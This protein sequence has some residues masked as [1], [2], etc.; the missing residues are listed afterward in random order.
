MP[1]IILLFPIL[2]IAC[3]EAELVIYNELKFDEEQELSYNYRLLK[4]YFY[5]PERIKEYEKYKGMEVDLMYQSLEDYFCG[6]NYIGDCYSR[7]TFYLPPEKSEEKIKEIENTKKYYSFG[8]ERTTKDDDLIDT[9][10]VSAVYPISPAAS[11][12]LKKHDKLLSANE[13]PLINEKAAIYLKSDSLFE[14]STVF[15]VLRGKDILTLPAM[16]KKEIQKPTVYLDSLEGIPSIRVTEYKVNTN[17]PNGTYAEFKNI[18]QEIKG[19][20]AAIMDLRGNPGGNI[21]HCTAMA[22]ELVP[23]D[24][25]LV[26]DERHYY[27]SKIGNV[28]DISHDFV[29]NYLTQ[30]GAGVNIRWVILMDRSSASCSERFTAAVKYNRPETVVIGQTSYGK[31]IG[32]VYATTYLNGLAYI[33]CLQ[34]FYPNGKTFHNIGI[35]PDIQTEPGDVETLFSEAIKAAQNSILAKR[36]TLPIRLGILPPERLAEKTEPGA[37]RR[38]EIPLFHQ[39]E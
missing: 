27:D 3:G 30:E 17:N 4:A 24:K 8:F 33:T 13:T 35:I 5:H 31:G 20:Q 28:K 18:L 37:H 6:A 15:K 19:A 12:G 2:F 34:T 9:L 21:G 39:Q 23:L 11:A 22:A 1:L 16:R 32:Q 10:I 29:K 14:D 36:S 7:Y 25:E 38:I 26:Y